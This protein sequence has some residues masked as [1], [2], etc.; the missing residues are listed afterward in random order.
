MVTHMLGQNG[1]PPA[2]SGNLS[3]SSFA[4]AC[5]SRSKSL[6]LSM[7]LGKHSSLTWP[8]HT[9]SAPF[10]A[11]FIFKAMLK[12]CIAVTYCRC[13][14]KLT[15]HPSGNWS[16]DWKRLPHSFL[17]QETQTCPS[18]ADSWWHVLFALARTSW[19]NRCAGLVLALDTWLLHLGCL[20]S[21][22]SMLGAST[23]T[24]SQYP[25]LQLAQ[26]DERCAGKQHSFIRAKEQIVHGGLL[27]I[28]NLP[29]L[30]VHI[31][32]FV[33]E[34]STSLPQ[35]YDPEMA[36]TSEN[37]YHVFVFQYC[38][39]GVVTYQHF[40][41]QMRFSLLQYMHIYRTRLGMV[42]LSIRE[43]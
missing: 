38:T 34:M 5:C 35:G 43:Q 30:H 25:L 3:W 27:L 24:D 18:T 23:P 16:V 19:A 9:Y 21:A 1:S 13:L 6:R 32:G 4:Q 11:P 39:D 29:D 36:N 40:F 22:G 20:L 12:Y 10:C 28:Q 8:H 42:Y 41:K 26:D 2:W 31:V 15:I 7:S 33:E 17:S 37:Q 14:R